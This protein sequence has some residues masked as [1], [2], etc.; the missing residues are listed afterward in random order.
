MSTAN[1]ESRTQC[2]VMS[3]SR[4]WT[5]DKMRNVV[6]VNGEKWSF[7]VYSNNK[8]PECRQVYED[9]VGFIGQD[10]ISGT[11]VKYRVKDFTKH[12][13]SRISPSGVKAYNIVVKY[14]DTIPL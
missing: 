14:G 3:A 1:N 7:S 5:K 12:K 6:T 2:C 8:T 9:T 11:M 10:Q 13:V 4:G